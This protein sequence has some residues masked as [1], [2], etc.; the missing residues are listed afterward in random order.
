MS[1]IN[2][3]S[4]GLQSAT[5]VPNRFIDE[6]MASANG[7]FV[8]IYL[9]LLRCMNQKDAHFSLSEIADRFEHTEKDIQRALHYWEKVNLLQLEYSADKQLAG[10]CMLSDTETVPPLAVTALAEPP[11]EVLVPDA[12]SAQTHVNENE[13]D[14]PEDEIKQKKDSYTLDELSAFQERED[15]REILFITE[16]Y[17]GRTLNPMEIRTIL[18]WYDG[19]GM[20]TELIE[21]LIE[22]SIGNNHT[23]LRYMEKIALNWK[24]ENICTVKQARI[25]KSLY[26]KTAIFVMKQ[27]GIAGRNLVES[28]LTYINKWFNEF[29]FSNEIVQEAC[30]RT[31]SSI[32]KPNFE[33]ADQIL[34]NWHTQKVRHRD[35]I[36]KI[37]LSYKKLQSSG[38]TPEQRQKKV[39][40]NKFNNFTQRSY[41]FN[42]LE[43]QLLDSNK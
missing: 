12:P 3:H 17:L 8:K 33:Y 14:A 2:L 22:T 27:F 41:D 6:Y 23:S 21:Y 16:S 9:Y 25:A 5:Y 38:F 36:L 11:N 19:L 1:D 20:A 42:I 7:E 10:I 37:D 43:K 31:L 26:S 30:K 34:T 29:A 40:S 15:I 32:G 24:D 35:D 13:V 39:A 28:E 18:F 4:S